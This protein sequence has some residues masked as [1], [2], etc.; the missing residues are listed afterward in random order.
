MR[1]MLTLLLLLALAGP[2][3]GVVNIDW[4]TVGD[5]GNVDDTP[6][7]GGV[8]EPYQISKFEVTNAQY[9][10]FLNAVYWAFEFPS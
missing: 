9:T 1:S 3:L 2:A 8:A 10:D 4:I 7:F 6:E 5:P